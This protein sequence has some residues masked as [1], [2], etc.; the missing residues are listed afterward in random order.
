[1]ENG[2]DN[3]DTFVI[4]EMNTYRFMFRGAGR[5]RASAHAAVLK[6][7]QAHRTVLLALYPDR[8]DTIPD[9]TQ[10]EDHFKIYYLE[11]ADNGGY[12]DSQRLI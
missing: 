7:W 3:T 9:E 4:A 11:F 5:D 12:R 6:A 1:M 10:M 8:A 2:T